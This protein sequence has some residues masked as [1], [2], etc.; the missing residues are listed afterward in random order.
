MSAPR[1]LIVPDKFKTSLSAPEAAQAL[2][3]GFKKIWPA[4]QIHSLPMADGGEGTADILTQLLQGEMLSIPATSAAPNSKVITSKVGWVPTRK[5]AIIDSSDAAGLWRIDSAERNPWK[6]STFGLGLCIRAALQRGAKEIYLGLGGSATNDLGAGLA[7]ALGWQFLDAQGAMVYPIPANFTGIRR[8]LPPDKL[9]NCS[10]TALSDVATP[11][12]GPKGCT[13]LFAEQKGL[14]TTDFSEMEKAVSHMADLI[15]KNLPTPQRD[16]PGAGAAGGLG[17]AILTFLQGKITPGFDFLADKLQLEENIKNN[18]LIVTAEGRLDQQTLHGKVPSGILKLARRHHKPVIAFGG[19]LEN[20]DLLLDS[21][22]GLV[23][24]PAGP[25]SLTKSID[26]ASELL[27]N[28]AARTAR[29][30]SIQL[31]L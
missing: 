4:A 5:L 17:F 7:Q 30:L 2:G 6:S 12:L 27:E 21:F 26:N 14:P 25:I 24:L 18:D 8:I 29:L 11:L 23:T 16:T 10:F 31:N 1:I 28:A 22:S 9:P 15:E 3:K 13:R 19:T 20:E